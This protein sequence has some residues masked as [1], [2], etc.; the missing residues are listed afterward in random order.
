MDRISSLPDSILCDILSYLP[1]KEAVCT[2]I[3]SRR[4]RHVWKDLQVIDIHDK[5]FMWSP[6]YE[7]RHARFDSFVN[8]I[9]AQR[10]AGSYPIQKIRLNCAPISEE[11][12]STL[13]DA[14]IGPHLQ[15]LYLRI[16]LYNCAVDPFTLPE[17]I[18]TCPSLNSLVLDGHINFFHGPE[19]SNVDVDLPSLKNLNL[20]C[21]FVNPQDLSS[22]CPALENLKLNLQD[23][24][25]H[26]PEIR[27]PRTLKSLT[28]VHNS[29][30][31]K[32]ISLLEIY[33]PSLEYLN[34]SIQ[35]RFE[36]NHYLNKGIE[37]SVMN[38]PNI[39][40]A[41]LSIVECAENFGWVL[42]LLQALRETKLLALKHLTTQCICRVPGLEFPA[43]HRLLNLELDLPPFNES[44][45]LNL[46][47]NCHVL[48]R[49][50]VNIRPV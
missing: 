39:V 36:K 27:M 28:F 34:L 45:L 9:L 6:K 42:L 40:E 35:N 43:F 8:A 3:L 17:G 12:I 37:V 10:N 30:I 29:D 7:E 25:L 49:L 18:F 32:G 26:L 31:C 33:T 2:S 1:T 38:F 47:H 44:F 14:V 21:Y 11:T 19:V 48:D 13:L 22:R 20:H 4:W 41:H 5:P 23:C 16:R 15:E 24:F 50:V 46:L